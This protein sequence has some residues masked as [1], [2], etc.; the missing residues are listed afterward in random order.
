MTFHCA[1]KRNIAVDSW[2]FPKRIHLKVQKR[3]FFIYCVRRGKSLRSWSHLFVLPLKVIWV[4][5]ALAKWE[6]FSYY[7]ALTVCRKKR[8][9]K[10][11]FK[12]LFFSEHCESEINIW[13]G[14]KELYMKKLTWQG[15]APCSGK[16][17]PCSNLEMSWKWMLTCVSSD[18][19]CGK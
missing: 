4:F 17:I 11:Q 6:V 19:F 7:K 9:T 12:F 15:L 16:S 14:F 5:F 18:L 13:I 1:W 10:F 2:S 8:I 3:Y